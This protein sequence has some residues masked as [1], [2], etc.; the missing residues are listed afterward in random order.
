MT[1]SK[2]YYTNKSSVI[3]AK[4]N[5]W[6]N[7]LAHTIKKGKKIT[8]FAS[9]KHIVADPQTGVV[10]AET[11]IIGHQ[12]V[13]DKEEF[14]KFFGAGI[15]EVFELSRPAK[16]VFRV[17]LRAYLAQSNQP[18]QLYIGFDAMIDDFG[19]DKSR[20]TFN[21]GMNEL[22]VKGFIAPVERRDSMY[23]VNPNLFYKGDRIRIVQDIVV[24][25]SASHKQLLRE[26]A[27][28]RTEQHTLDLS[29][30]KEP[31]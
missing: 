10:L 22:C 29:T 24:Q 1:D 11:A 18:D 4:E 20:T 30:A 3:A 23:W 7:V 13:V 28:Q 27:A 19:Y 2:K 16:D 14:V 6:A 17:V 31:A 9:T 21:N 5:P 26:E 8:G 15:E 25:G 12:K